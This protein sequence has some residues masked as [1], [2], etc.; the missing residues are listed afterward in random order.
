MRLKG[1]T[2][3][4]I[5]EL[6]N[7]WRDGGQINR[8]REYWQIDRHTNMSADS[9]IHLNKLD[10][11]S[12]SFL[13]MNNIFYTQY[14]IRLSHIRYYAK[15]LQRLQVEVFRDDVCNK[16]VKIIQH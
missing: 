7:G 9:W 8:H 15:T 5:D 11:Q 6:L 1:Y 2:E 4:Q 16:K 12:M 3:S 14:K 13:T 10:T